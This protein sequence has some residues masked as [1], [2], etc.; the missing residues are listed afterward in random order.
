MGAYGGEHY[1]I[2]FHEPEVLVVLVSGGSDYLQRTAARSGESR[3]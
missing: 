2:T 3:S 1:A